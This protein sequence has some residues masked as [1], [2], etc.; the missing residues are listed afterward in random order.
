MERANEQPEDEA[1]R[2]ALAAAARQRFMTLAKLPE[3]QIDLAEAMLVIAAEDYP[4]MDIG[5]YLQQL[6]DLARRVRDLLSP[7]A[8]ERPASPNVA[9]LPSAI[10]PVGERPAQRPSGDPDER[11]FAALH[12]VLFVEEG[13]TGDNSDAWYARGSYLNQVLLHKRGLPISLSVLYCEVARRAGLDAA[14]I[15]LP[16]HFVAEFRGQHMRRL[17]DPFHRGRRLDP[18]EA[19]VLASGGRG[20][21]VDLPPEVFL[22]ASKKRILARVLTNLKEYYRRHG[23]V[24]KALSAVERLLAL[25]PS[26][27]QVRDRGLILAQMNLPGP[28]WFDL[29]LYARLADG[30]ADAP[31]VEDA[32]AQLWKRMGRLN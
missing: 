18:E 29:K 7:E 2:A 32:A 14:G 8:A 22:P 25:S 11:A 24:F 23:P 19:A 1:T 6:D 15:S 30:A 5:A 16:S 27:D 3:D 28:A 20:V 21:P 12:R 13:F 10:P 17:L 4:G 9:G 31:L 26:L